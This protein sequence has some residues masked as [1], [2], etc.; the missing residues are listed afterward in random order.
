MN[1]IDAVA[2]CD[3]AADGGLD[4]VVIV[5]IDGEES[6]L[7]GLADGDH[8]VTASGADAAYAIDAVIA[9]DAESPSASITV[10]GVGAAPMPAGA[11]PMALA[12]SLAVAPAAA[13]SAVQLPATGAAA[14]AM[15]AGA[16]M[17]VA[18]G[19]IL[20]RLGRPAA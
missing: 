4:G 12:T 8:R 9:C 5:W 11:E 7:V 10:A 17:L 14:G 16:L 3:S 13:P 20:R 19:A 2:S 6:S 18:T 1:D 15:L